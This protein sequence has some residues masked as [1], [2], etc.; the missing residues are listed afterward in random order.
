MNKTGEKF[1]KLEAELK[2]AREQEAEK[3]AWLMYILSLSHASTHLN[4]PAHIK[5]AIDRIEGAARM[6][7]KNMPV[8]ADLPARIMSGEVFREGKR[9]NISKK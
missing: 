3:A 7:V 6:A 5:K 1:K 4:E 9:L 8:P 2:K